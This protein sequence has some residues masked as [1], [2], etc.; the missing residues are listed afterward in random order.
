MYQKGPLGNGKMIPLLKSWCYFRIFHRLYMSP[1]YCHPL[2]L[3][4]IPFQFTSSVLGISLKNFSLIVCML[5]WSM[6][7]WTRAA[8]TA[9]S[10]DTNQTLMKTSE[11]LPGPLALSHT[12]PN[13]TLLLTPKSTP[14]IGAIVGKSNCASQEFKDVEVWGS[15]KQPCS[16]LSRSVKLLFILF[17]ISWLSAGLFFSQW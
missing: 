6:Q 7:H 13:H 14:L 15:F 5:L 11:P 16:L 10:P 3:T 17:S 1:C 9:S 2:S 4:H 12:V 8:H